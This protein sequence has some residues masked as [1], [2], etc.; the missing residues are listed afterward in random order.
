[1]V[2]G[3]S[4][5]VGS[6]YLR[7]TPRA[8]FT[9]IQSKG[10]RI[11]S[12]LGRG[13]AVSGVFTYRGACFVTFMGNASEKNIFQKWSTPRAPLQ[14]ELSKSALYKLE[15]RMAAVE[16]SLVPP[17]T[18]ERVDRDLCYMRLLEPNNKEYK[19]SNK[20]PAF[21]FF[22]FLGAGLGG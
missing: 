5:K 8:T 6:T 17:M 4:S 11:H 10:F 16:M 20:V 19:I 15:P 22:C 3:N 2:G 7:N 1:M 13:I 14:V 9:N 18:D 12:W 21:R